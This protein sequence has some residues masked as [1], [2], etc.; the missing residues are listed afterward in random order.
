M[1]PA[2]VKYQHVQSRVKHQMD[3]HKQVHRQMK[4]QNRVP[5]KDAQIYYKPPTP[6]QHPPHQEAPRAGQHL[7]QQAAA[8]R[9]RPSPAKTTADFDD[10]HPV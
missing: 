10:V 7:Q 3:Y 2:G 8:L 9:R 5:S 1:Q 6:N 4:C